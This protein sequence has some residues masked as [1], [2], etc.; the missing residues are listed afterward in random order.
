VGLRYFDLGYASAMAYVLLIVVM[1][2]VTLFFR[3]LRETYA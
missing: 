2:I 3:R 1:I